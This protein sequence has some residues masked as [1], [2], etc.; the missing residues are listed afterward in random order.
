MNDDGL[1]ASCFFPFRPPGEAALELVRLVLGPWRT[2]RLG[3]R[4]RPTSRER[5][6]GDLYGGVRRLANDLC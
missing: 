1:S 3:P 2:K 5:F 6:V 4:L